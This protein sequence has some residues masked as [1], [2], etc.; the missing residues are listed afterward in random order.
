M[1]EDPPPVT[2]SFRA[3]VAP[4]PVPAGP[5]AAQALLLLPRV[6]AAPAL[7]APD[8][9]DVGVAEPQAPERPQLPTQSVRFNNDDILQTDEVPIFIAGDS[10]DSF[11]DTTCENSVYLCIFPTASISEN[12]QVYLLLMIS[13]R[14]YHLGTIMKKLFKTKYSPKRAVLRLMSQLLH[15]IS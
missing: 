13:G 5:A 3:P 1:T 6:A 4:A 14:D 8:T 10:N 7:V 15:R 12:P 11:A 2:V 9:A